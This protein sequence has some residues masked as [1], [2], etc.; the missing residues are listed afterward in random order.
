[1]FG[2]GYMRLCFILTMG[3][4]V[5]F[6]GIKVMAGTANEVELEKNIVP[7]GS[8]EEG[9]NEPFFWKGNI[10]SG[11]ECIL[12]WETEGSDEGKRCISIEILD[13]DKDNESSGTW[14]SEYFSVESGRD[15]LFS[16]KG[17]LM[18]K[19]TTVVAL[20]IES[21]DGRYIFPSDDLF[22][23]D[24][25]W[26]VS[27]KG[28]G[29]LI[30]PEGVSR[31][32]CRFTFFG[33]NTNQKVWI[34]DVKLTPLPRLN[35]KEES[36]VFSDSFN[37]ITRWEEI[38]GLR[39]DW[40][41]VNDDGNY[42]LEYHSNMFGAI[43]TELMEESS[44]DF[45]VKL[46][47]KKLEKILEE[48]GKAVG[49]GPLVVMDEVGDKLCGYDYIFYICTRSSEWGAIEIYK[50][51]IDER[52][53]GYGNTKVVFKSMGRILEINQWYE[54]ILQKTGGL[55]KIFVDGVPIVAWYDFEFLKKSVRKLVLYFHSGR[56][57][58]G[59]Q[60]DDLVVV[61]VKEVK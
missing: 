20:K 51:G 46:K 25:S 59:Y 38:W 28:T 30:I 8:F 6:V 18:H 58:G 34:D 24:T 47:I 7:N 17:K 5:F 19:D 1:M 29:I 14:E 55:F 16:V 52:Y 50:Y 23:G 10:V 13:G 57:N 31:I 60:I 36:P 33:S 22:F 43:V 61:P 37:D 39:D 35:L 11:T 4:L 53:V 15:Y 48:T 41:I 40:K 9:T 49:F 21:E 12:K 26:G 27:G 56:L 54:I 32:R 3:F 2:K 42:V 44:A 45:R